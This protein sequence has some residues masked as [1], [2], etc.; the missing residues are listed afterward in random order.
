[1]SANSASSMPHPTAA[2][3]TAAMT[4]HSQSSAA[5]AAGVG[6][7]RTIGGCDVCDTA[8]GPAMISCTSSP[9]QKAG[10]APVTITQR[11][12]GSAEAMRNADSSSSY[13]RK[14]RALRRCGR[15]SVIV[16]T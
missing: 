13:A 10:S 7:G 3:F 4:G 9:E 11:I 15:F 12:S 8:F 2:P 16:A 5:I 14:L 1:M 6:L